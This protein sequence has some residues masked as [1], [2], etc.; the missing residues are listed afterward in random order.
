MCGLGE[1]RGMMQASTCMKRTC[2]RLSCKTSRRLLSLRSAV[3]FFQAEDGIRDKLVTGVQTCALP[4][5]RAVLALLNNG[6][7]ANVAGGHGETPLIMAAGYGHT[8][9]VRILLEHGANARA[10]LPNR[11]EERRVGEEGRSRWSPYH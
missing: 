7:N 6:A 5:S 1:N 11:S 9:I 3:F 2:P 4:I 10:T 8:D